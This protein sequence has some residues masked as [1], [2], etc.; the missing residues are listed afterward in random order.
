[1]RVGNCTHFVDLVVVLWVEFEDFRA[2][3]VIEIP[4]EVI[5]AAIEVYPPFLAFHEPGML[6][7]QDPVE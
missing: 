7:S 3:Y 4:D 6:F 5:Y 1:M 2:F